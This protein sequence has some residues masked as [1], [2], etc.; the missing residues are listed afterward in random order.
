MWFWIIYFVSNFPTPGTALQ[1]QSAGA[2]TPDIPQTS[3]GSSPA[4]QLH[5]EQFLFPLWESPLVW[6]RKRERRIPAFP[7]LRDAEVLKLPSWCSHGGE[8]WPRDS[9][10][11]DV[12]QGR[13]ETL[14]CPCRQKK[15]VNTLSQTLMW[16]FF[17][18]LQ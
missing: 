2:T 3:L 18:V 6:K 12:G 4:G 7:S 9:L 15:W 11:K 8:H 17:V 16:D 1:C 10:L 14:G 5:Q 13:R